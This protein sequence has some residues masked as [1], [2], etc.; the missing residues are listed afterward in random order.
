MVR[1]DRHPNVYA[2]YIPAAINYDRVWADTIADTA[3]IATAVRM[4]LGPT[5]L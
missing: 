3:R 2:H 1:V 4:R 5:P